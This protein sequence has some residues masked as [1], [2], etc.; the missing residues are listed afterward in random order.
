MTNSNF[1]V[2]TVRDVKLCLCSCSLKYK[3]NTR[4]IRIKTS[5]WSCFRLGAFK[6]SKEDAKQNQ[7][8]RNPESGHHKVD[9]IKVNSII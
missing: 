2:D 1:S 4:R 7:D 8:T 5:S 6:E 3:T 9:I